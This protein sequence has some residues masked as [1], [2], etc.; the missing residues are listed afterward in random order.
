MCV[1]LVSMVIYPGSLG[2]G[3]SASTSVFV[4]IVAGMVPEWWTPPRCGDTHTHT[5]VINEGVNFNK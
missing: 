2:N 5:R 3:R 1:A 4:T